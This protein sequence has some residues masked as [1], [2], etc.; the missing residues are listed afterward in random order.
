MKKRKKD[1]FII[2]YEGR[3]FGNQY[4]DS[5]L[6]DLFDHFIKIGKGSFGVVYAS[7]KKSDSADVAIKVIELSKVKNFKYID[8]EFKF[9]SKSNCSNIV[10]YEAAY[11]CREEDYIWVSISIF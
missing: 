3:S 5:S 6:N 10:K 4:P 7:K 8:K 11:Y 9:H 1:D 2:D